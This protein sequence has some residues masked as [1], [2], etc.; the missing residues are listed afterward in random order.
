MDRA[1]AE[2]GAAELVDVRPGAGSGVHAVSEE[3]VG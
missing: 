2:M 3:R 1:Y